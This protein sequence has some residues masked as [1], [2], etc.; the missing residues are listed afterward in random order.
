MF[1]GWDH[2][3][4]SNYFG[5]RAPFEDKKYHEYVIA[6]GVDP[7]LVVCGTFAQLS[8]GPKKAG[9]PFRFISPKSSICSICVLLSSLGFGGNPSLLGLGGGRKLF[10]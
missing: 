9:V 4:P 1:L 6:P 5:F 10:L 2:F 3:Y 8:P 7:G